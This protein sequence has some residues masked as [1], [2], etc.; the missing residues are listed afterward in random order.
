[1]IST[2]NI[3]RYGDNALGEIAVMLSL[4]G[5]WELMPQTGLTLGSPEDLRQ[6]CQ[7]AT[8]DVREAVYDAD[9]VMG[10]V[11]WYHLVGRALRQDD[12]STLSKPDRLAFY[13]W[14]ENG[15]T[16]S[17]HEFPHRLFWSSA[18]RWTAR[19]DALAQLVDSP[20]L[21]VMTA[22]A[23]DV[24]KAVDSAK[25]AAARQKLA[26]NK[27]SY[28]DTWQKAKFHINIVPDVMISP[29][30]IRLN[31]MRRAHVLRDATQ[32]Y[33]E[34][35]G[36]VEVLERMAILY[37]QQ[38]ETSEHLKAYV[39]DVDAFRVKHLWSDRFREAIL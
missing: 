35:G 15:Q 19:Y 11:R 12:F 20:D 38:K 33:R 26:Q 1:M 4:E 32:T 37:A 34:Q 5:I 28:F 13:D 16:G 6:I 21:D 22:F 36:D 7:R 17:V 23:N 29:P 27:D 10:W 8:A 39:A 14:L 30:L 25:Y 24:V 2:P 31:F 18:C 9:D 3:D